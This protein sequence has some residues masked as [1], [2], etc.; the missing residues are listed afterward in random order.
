MSRGVV[1]IVVG[2]SNTP[3]VGISEASTARA[4]RFA[5]EVS[6]LRASEFVVA[7]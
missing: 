2:A 6:C 5:A 4:Q 1:W 7:A 3:H